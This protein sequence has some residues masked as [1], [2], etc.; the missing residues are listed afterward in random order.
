[1]NRLKKVVYKHRIRVKEFLSD[2]DR[3]RSGTMHENFF[4]TSLSMAGID[5][6]L[7]AQQIETIVDAYRVQVTPSL[8]M[9]DWVKFVDDVETIFTLKVCSTWPLLDS[10]RMDAIACGQAAQGQQIYHQQALRMQGLEK[11][12]LTTI[13]AEPTELLDKTRYQFCRKQLCYK[14]E[15][16]LNRV[17]DGMAS[18]AAKRGMLVKPFFEDA[19]RDP[20][21]VRMINHVTPQQF[22][23]VRSQ[24][25]TGRCHTC[26]NTC[27]SFRML[28]SA[29]LRGFG[30]R[31]SMW[32]VWRCIRH[33]HP[34]LVCDGVYNASTS[35]EM[36]WS[37]SLLMVGFIMLARCS[38]DQDQLV[39]VS[40]CCCMPPK[41][42]LARIR[43][44]TSLNK[45]SGVECQAWNE[46]GGL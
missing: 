46:R 43:W 39:A 7:S 38:D 4:I 5:R 11:S 12:P 18:K 28:F 13:P 9:I 20:N 15:D 34:A 30:E 44:I 33:C 16:E 23:Q 24:A 21:S 22:K 41:F 25:S 1:M 42:R 31:T 40:V 29:S 37:S 45:C 8:S 3:L 2:F 26:R 36:G 10:M 19:S 14:K 6:K 35:C 32:L 27:P 17:L